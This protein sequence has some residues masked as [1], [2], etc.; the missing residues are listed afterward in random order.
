MRPR[1]ADEARARA[2]AL[3]NRRERQ[4]TDA[5]MAERRAA[6]EAASDRMRERQRLARER[7]ANYRPPVRRDDGAV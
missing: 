7:K 4:R 3:F 5:T 1:F 6:E 2:E